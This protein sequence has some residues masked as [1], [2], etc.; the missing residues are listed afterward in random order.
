MLSM[1]NITRLLIQGVRLRDQLGLLR[2]MEVGGGEEF[3]HGP[4]DGFCA[5]YMT[6]KLLRMFRKF[7]SYP[8]LSQHRRVNTYNRAGKRQS[9]LSHDADHAENCAT[10]LADQCAGLSD[11]S[12]IRGPRRKGL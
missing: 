7:R 11:G 3:A 12:I 10:P 5:R 6:E 4:T 8:S 9:S 2:Y 1:N